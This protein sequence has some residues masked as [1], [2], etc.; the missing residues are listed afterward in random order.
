MEIKYKKIKVS[1]LLHLDGGGRGFG[2]EYVNVVKRIGKV[3][4]VSE[5]CSGCGFIG[6]SLLAHGLCDKLTLL[7]ANEEAI[8]FCKQTIKNNKLENVTCYVSDGLESIPETEKWDLVVGNLPHWNEV[9]KE[10]SF[11]SRNVLYKN[12]MKYDPNFVV[13]KKF[14]QNI[15]K[16]LKENGTIL[17]QENGYASNYRDFLPMTEKNG[18]NVVNVFG[19]RPATFQ[20]IKGR[21]TTNYYFIEVT[22]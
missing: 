21:R 1:Y 14:Y 11:T 9:R 12:P 17:L 10:S 4:H 18:L 8:N 15:H 7:D 13:H 22:K 3:N 19:A 6:F 2:Q 16:F 5:F 20:Y